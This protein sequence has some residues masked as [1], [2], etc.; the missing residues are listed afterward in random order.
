MRSKKLRYLLYTMPTL[1]TNYELIKYEDF[2]MDPTSILTEWSKKY[3]LELNSTFM[4]PIKKEAYPIPEEIKKSI[5]EGVD[6]EID[7]K[8]GYYIK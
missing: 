6:W 7:N 5:N 3:N 8:L 2:I 1:V 4:P